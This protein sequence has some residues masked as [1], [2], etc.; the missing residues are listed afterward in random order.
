VSDRSA[1]T[2]V[3]LLVS[4]AVIAVLIGLI[5]P[6][7]GHIQDAA[8]KVVCASNLRQIG[9]TLSMYRDDH[10]GFFPAARAEPGRAADQ[11]DPQLA[12][13]GEHPDS[14]SGFGW[15]VG[16][17]YLSTPQV[18]YCPAHTGDITSEAYADAWMMLDQPIRT[19]YAYRAELVPSGDIL[20]RPQSFAEAR[21][22][23]SIL[24]SDAFSNIN[25][26][27]HASG[28]NTLSLG[29]DVAWRPDTNGRFQTIIA[30]A[31][32]GG[33]SPDTGWTLLDGDGDGPGGS[34]PEQP[35]VNRFGYHR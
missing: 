18:F 6:T 14:W 33:I 5:S 19:N 7:L 20:D 12:H 22:P 30:A 26:I 29:L 16:T 15:L 10:D 2:L 27:N 13:T 25:E 24:A 35:S 21:S 4:M 8:R 3:D 32:A 31:G 9:L 28:F 1:F 11:V 23:S 34:G 17:G